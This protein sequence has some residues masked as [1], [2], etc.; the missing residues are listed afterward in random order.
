GFHLENITGTGRPNLEVEG[1]IS[2]DGL[3]N[4]SNSANVRYASHNGRF[5]RVSSSRRTKADITDLSIDA[6]VALKLR[7]RRWRDINTDE[8]VVG[9]VAEEVA[10]VAPPEFIEWGEDGS[11]EGIAYDRLIT[12]YHAKIAQQ[13]ERIGALEAR[14]SAS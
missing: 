6:D 5:Y 11:T 4:S 1:W 13:E 7:P 12:L 14:L 3:T 10:E 8:S 2:A 9:Y